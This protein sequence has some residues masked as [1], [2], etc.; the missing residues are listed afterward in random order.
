[1]KLKQ[2]I[3][4][5]VTVEANAKG[6]TPKDWAALGS[7]YIEHLMESPECPWYGTHV[8]TDALQLFGCHPFEVTNAKVGSHLCE[9]QI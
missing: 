7:R 3:R 9:M 2:G 5:D 4:V 1:M 8:S 6:T